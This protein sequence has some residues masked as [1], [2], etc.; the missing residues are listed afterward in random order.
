MGSDAS[1]SLRVFETTVPA[2]PSFSALASMTVARVPSPMKLSSSESSPAVA[3]NSRPPAALSA[4]KPAF[5]LPRPSSASTHRC[6][7]TKLK[8]MRASKW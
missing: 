4:A 6:R 8:G 3:K 7:P 2:L 5:P 1:V